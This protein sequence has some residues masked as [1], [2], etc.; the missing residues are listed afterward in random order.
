M[1]VAFGKKSAAKAKDMYCVK[2]TASGRRVAKVVTKVSKTTGKARKVYNSSGAAVGA[3]VVCYPTKAKATAALKKAAKTSTT[4]KPKGGKKVT[5]SSAFGRRG[6]NKSANKKIKKMDY[7]YI[8]CVDPEREGSYRPFIVYLIR[9]EG[10][11]FKI[12]REKLY[13]GSYRVFAAP[14]ESTVYRVNTSGTPAQEKASKKRAK[15]RASRQAAE[16]ELLGH[17]GVDLRMSD[18]G[19]DHIMAIRGS[20][21]GGRLLRSMNSKEVDAIA[22]GE[23]SRGVANNLTLNGIRQSLD[24]STSYRGNSDISR[25]D[26]FGPN[27]INRS[28][29]NGIDKSDIKYRQGLNGSTHAIYKNTEGGVN[30]LNLNTKSVRT[31]YGDRSQS[32]IAGKMQFG[33]GS[34]FGRLA[35]GVSRFGNINYGFGSK[36][37]G[38][39]GSI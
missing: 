16:Y 5:K 14:E 39:N 19:R 34:Q 24:Y 1:T 23:L 36:Y 2:K 20:G 37:A 13:D 18:C 12:V 9:W 15:E 3:S 22:S 29:L 27:V 6:R 21:H 31:L 7:G 33:S 28:V 38:F 17:V 8:V 26:L 10:E 25:R 32:A 11:V 30:R 35:G 4:T